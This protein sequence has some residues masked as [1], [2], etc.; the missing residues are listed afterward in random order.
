MRL[1]DFWE[2]MNAHFGAAYA[3]S[4][5]KDQV[6]AELGG[7]TIA[8]AVDDGENLRWVW[9]VVCDVYEVPARSR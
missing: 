5:A 6:V 3:E 7:R 8:E 4:L 2:R 9:R 1:T